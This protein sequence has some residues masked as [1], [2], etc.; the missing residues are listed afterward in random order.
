MSLAFILNPAKRKRVIKKRKKVSR[1]KR[2]FIGN[3]D[4]LRRRRM[5]MPMSG[6]SLR[7]SREWREIVREMG[8]GRAIPRVRRFPKVGTLRNIGMPFER[9]KTMAKRKRTRRNENPKGMPRTKKGRAWR[10]MVKK[11]GVKKAASMRRGR[12]RAYAANPTNP[13][14]K[15][16][17]GH[18]IA[19][20]AGRARKKGLNIAATLRRRGV[21][22]AQI[23]RY[24][25]RHGMVMSHSKYLKRIPSG[26]KMYA[27]NP[28][29]IASLT[30]DFT[31]SV[32]SKEFLFDGVAA[33]GGILGAVAGETIITHIVSRKK[34]EAEKATAATPTIKFAGHLLGSIGTGI[35]VSLVTKNMRRGFVAASGG[36][37]YG[38]FRIAYAKINTSL[39]GKLFGM[40]LPMLGDYVELPQTGDYVEIPQT[41]DYVEIPQT[42]EVVPTEEMSQFV[43]EEE[44][45]QFV[46]EEDMSG[47]ED[48]E[49]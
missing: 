38:L 24:V 43:P 5:S 18:H 17:S 37:A 25:K 4:D 7:D 21:K 41:G 10:A 15:D 32:M 8:V 31:K 39:G 34:A 1:K 42:G 22:K 27:M 35:I 49:Y 48:I 2:D 45:S 9:R 33:F 12:K 30:K 26:A 13:W 19:G 28:A 47:S 3:I 46:P 23:K 44:M 6:R 20:L 14:F 29:G 36:V 40:T 11:Y 16:S